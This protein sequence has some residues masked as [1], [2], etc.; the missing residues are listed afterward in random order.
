MVIYMAIYV[1]ILVLV[2]LFSFSLIALILAIKKRNTYNTKA[3]TV[4][5]IISLVSNAVLLL[6]LVQE[7]VW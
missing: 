2:I 7:V 3:A 6:S 1:A 4:L 5:S